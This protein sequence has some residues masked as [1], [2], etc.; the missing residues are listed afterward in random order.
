MSFEKRKYVY[1]I[2]TPIAHRQLI[3]TIWVNGSF[4]DVHER[5]IISQLFIIAAAYVVATEV[6]NFSLNTEIC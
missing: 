4:A 5:A 3:N 6:Q 1:M 2:N